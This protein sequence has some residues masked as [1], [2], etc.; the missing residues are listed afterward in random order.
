M[1]IPISNTFKIV[2]L[3]LLFFLG[4]F[5]S[6]Q[7]QEASQEYQLKLAF[8]VNFARFIT[9]PEGSFALDPPRLT[10]CLFEKN[11]FGGAI[12]GIQGKKVGNRIL[13]V[14]EITN[15]DND[16]QCNVLFIGKTERTRVVALEQAVGQRPIVTISDIPGFAAAGGAIEFVLQDDKLSFIINKSIMNERGMQ[17]SS[18][19]LNLAVE[20]R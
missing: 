16:Q 19:L 5:N 8:I 9:W 1:G 6:L 3:C 20:T 13:K 15:L 17:P 12:E 10:L 4:S 18:S 11:P 7:A 14:K 2:W